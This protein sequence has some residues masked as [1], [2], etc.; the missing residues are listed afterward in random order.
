VLAA[1]ATT[2][3]SQ[4]SRRGPFAFY[5]G[6]ALTEDG[7]AW[8]SQFDVLVTHDPLPREQVERLHAAGTKLVLYEWSVAFYESRATEWQRSLLRDHRGL[9]HD[10]PLTGGAGSTTAPAWYFD[11]S[12]PD[13]A[14]LRAA[15]LIARLSSTG[16]DGVFLDTT[17]VASVHP[18]ARAEY[19]KRNAATPYDLAYSRFLR[20]LRARLPNGIIFTNQGYRSAEHYLPWVDWD[21]TESLITG[22]AGDSWRVR[23]WNDPANPWNSTHFVMRTMI[24]PVAE[25]Y[26]HVRFGHLNYNDAADPEVTRLV[27]A[28]GHLFGGEGYVSVE[29]VAATSP[30]YFVNPGKPASTRIDHD[31]GQLSYRF[32]DELL[33]AVSSASQPVAITMPC[34]SVATVPASPDRP[35][36]FF[37]DNKGGCG[38]PR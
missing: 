23:S 29:G 33:I 31:G 20:E 25:R 37:F 10:V 34:G 12:S 3:P 36:A 28:I 24:E 7:L 6:P 27:V 13:H 32:F 1:C 2:Q 15:D 26:P 22:P 30:H 18:V 5:Y 9:L 4:V 17:T 11:P 16:Y 8:Y 14:R 35:R 21:L 38:R 19:E